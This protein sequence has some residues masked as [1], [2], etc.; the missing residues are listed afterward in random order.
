MVGPVAHVERGLGWN[1]VIPA[2][3]HNGRTG[4]NYLAVLKCLDRLGPND[5]LWAL[6][7]ACCTTR[8]TGPR[9][10][11]AANKDKAGIGRQPAVRFF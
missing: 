4:P 11:Q 8:T 9:P 7:A 10:G 3:C 6:P 5:R 1:V 2:Q